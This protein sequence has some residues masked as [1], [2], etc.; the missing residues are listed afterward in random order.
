M[1]SNISHNTIIIVFL[2][3][4]C[5][6]CAFSEGMIQ[7]HLEGWRF[8]QVLLN[9]NLRFSKTLL[10]GYQRGIVIKKNE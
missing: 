7:L 1:R 6:G 2:F 9:E 3:R 4:V 5:C 10:N 8:E